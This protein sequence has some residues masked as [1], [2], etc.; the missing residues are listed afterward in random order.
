MT[1]NLGR[2][3]YYAIGMLLRSRNALGYICIDWHSN[4]RVN[5][6]KRDILDLS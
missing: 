5:C 1:N 4:F 2:R 6:A 3:K